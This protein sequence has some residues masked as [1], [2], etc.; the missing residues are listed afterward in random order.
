MNFNNELKK[1]TTISSDIIDYIITEYV[2]GDKTYWKEKNAKVID[3]IN[4]LPKL[5]SNS[6]FRVSYLFYPYDRDGLYNRNF[7]NHPKKTNNYN[8]FDE[9]IASITSEFYNIRQMTKNNTNN[10][11]NTNKI[12]IKF[13]RRLLNQKQTKKL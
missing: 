8:M 11:N 13:R 12:I 1:Y 3:K 9:V 7:V 5:D 2:S 6:L 10:T 4:M